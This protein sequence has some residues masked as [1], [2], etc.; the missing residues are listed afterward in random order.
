MV[1]MKQIKMIVDEVYA[2]HEGRIST[3]Y[4]GCFHYHAGC[5]ASIIKEILEEDDD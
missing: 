1:D 3:H 5:L 4:E 2:T